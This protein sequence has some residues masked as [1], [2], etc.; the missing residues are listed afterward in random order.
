MALVLKVMPLPDG[1]KNLT[2][3]TLLLVQYQSV[4]DRQADRL[5]DGLAI[6]ILCSACWGCCVYV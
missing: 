2:I 1:G 5:T 3:C 4:M 6:T